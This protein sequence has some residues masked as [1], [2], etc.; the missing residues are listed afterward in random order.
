MFNS[1][2]SGVNTQQRRFFQ[3]MVYTLLVDADEAAE[4]AG[5]RAG[6]VGYLLC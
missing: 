4:V 1:R 5:P 3:V 2:E 6:L